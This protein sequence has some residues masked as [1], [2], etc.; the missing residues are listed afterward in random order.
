[1]RLL[2][3]KE[4]FFSQ[5]DADIANVVEIAGEL[6]E[7]LRSF[8][9]LA[10]RQARIKELEHRGDAITHNLATEIH[11]TFVTPL[12]KEDIA[13]VASGIDDIADYVDAVGDRIVL[14]QIPGSTEEARQLADLIVD[15]VLI[16]KDAVA[17]LRDPRN[18]PQIIEACRQIHRLENE[19]DTVY[20]RALGRLLNTPGADPIEVIKWKE[21]YDRLEM[22]VDKCEDVSNTFE[23]IL[24]KYG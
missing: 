19:S 20:R 17:L 8:D 1:M 21:I 5:F 16:L 23:S 13:A 18:A 4:T 12:D 14:Y 3:R 2:P 24:L 22:A 9:R 10:E 15:A 6:R 11:A 7:M